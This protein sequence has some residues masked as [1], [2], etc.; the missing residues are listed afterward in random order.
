MKKFY[1]EKNILPLTLQWDT[2]KTN[3]LMQRICSPDVLWWSQNPTWCWPF[4]WFVVKVNSQ[5][6]EC[7]WNGF[8]VMF[9]WILVEKDILQKVS[10][11]KQRAFQQPVSWA[12]AFITVMQHWNCAIALAESYFTFSVLLFWSSMSTIELFTYTI[13]ATAPI[14]LKTNF[15]RL[16][17][18]KVV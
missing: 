16:L 12:K 4:A 9:C 3:Q 8:P 13:Y 17:S 1:Q 14:K 2:S 7:H 10:S 18:Q 5:D 11:V 15:Y 6:W